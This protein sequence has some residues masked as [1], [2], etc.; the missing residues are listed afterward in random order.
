[1]LQTWGI[2]P[3][4]SLRVALF[5]GGMATLIAFI[6]LLF[7]TKTTATLEAPAPAESSP[8]T[9]QVHTPH[10]TSDIP[11]LETPAAASDRR[12]IG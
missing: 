11:A 1:G 8:Q 6:P 3:L 2:T 12:V 4:S 7:I 10:S 5:L 9:E